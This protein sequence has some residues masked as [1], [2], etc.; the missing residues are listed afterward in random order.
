M[1]GYLFFLLGVWIVRIIPMRGLYIISDGVSWLLFHV[2]KYR[3][4]VV[5]ENFRRC[6]ADKDQTWI[7]YHTREYFRYLADLLLEGVKSL[8][9]SIEELN[10][11][12]TVNVPDFMNRAPYKGSHVIL[13]SSHY[14]NWEYATRA[15]PVQI[16]SHIMGGIHSR[17]KNKR[18]YRYMNKYR[19]STGMWLIP[20]D[21]AKSALRRTDI[22]PTAFLFLSDQ[23]P[24]SPERAYWTN[25]LGTPTGF[26]PGAEI[27]AKK[28]NFP[29]ALILVKRIARGKYQLNFHDIC[30]TPSDHEDGYIMKKYAQLLEEL[31][32]ENPIPWLWSHKR[33]KHKMPEGAFWIEERVQ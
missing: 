10:E 5:S 28:L 12:F 26:V 24:S 14:G 25:F 29:V 1:I 18:I 30:R 20:T 2:I 31:I 22:D 23:N 21:E 27:Y 17:I 33:W 7:D 32:E 3:R 19:G 9:M 6:F 11:R 13:M 8:H 16:K 15:F 4:E